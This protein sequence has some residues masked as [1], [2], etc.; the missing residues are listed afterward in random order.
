MKRQ[1]EQ[2]KLYVGL[3]NPG[4]AYTWT[5][6]NIGERVLSELAMRQGWSWHREKKFDGLVAKG[7]IGD[8]RVHLLLPLTYMNASGRSVQAYLN[9]YRMEIDAVTVVTDDTALAFGQMRL[10]PGGGAGSHR[11]LQSIEQSLGGRQGY[12][13]LRIGIGS[14]PAL[15]PLA[16]YVLNPFSADERLKLP[17][18]LKAGAEIL[19]RLAQEPLERLMN[20]INT[21][22]PPERQ[23]CISNPSQTSI[24]KSG[25]S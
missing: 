2:Q 18:L 23:D 12:A 22:Q 24:E 20:Q 1:A 14:P 11:G 15:L 8:C 3:G 5:R 10:R 13:R 17:A 25:E 7:L 4:D 16:D 6:H 19:E 21:R 9:F